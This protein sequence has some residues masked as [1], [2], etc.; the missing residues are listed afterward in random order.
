MAKKPLTITGIALI[1]LGVALA[2][3]PFLAMLTGG[4]F[5][6]TFALGGGALGILGAFLVLLGTGRI[7]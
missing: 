5:R 2:A 7:D 3:S 4:T 6:I 1:V